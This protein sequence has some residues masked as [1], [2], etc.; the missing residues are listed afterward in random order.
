M[1]SFVNQ[2]QDIKLYKSLVETTVG[3]AVESQ[4]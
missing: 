2:V 4:I 3:V 1:L